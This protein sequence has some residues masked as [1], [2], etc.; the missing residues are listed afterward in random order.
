[1]P[2]IQQKINKGI[3]S[4]NLYEVL[5]DNVWKDNFKLTKP[6]WN[7]NITTMNK[8]G[9]EMMADYFQHL[10]V[11]KKQEVYADFDFNKYR[12]FRDKYGYVNSYKKIPWNFDR[13]PN[14]FGLVDRNPMRASLEDTPRAYD[15]EE[16]YKAKGL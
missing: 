8:K 3:V 7:G 13:D 6:D 15:N 1:M 12:S 11:W 5:P 9:G 14:S 2:N 16:Y 10:D 4:K